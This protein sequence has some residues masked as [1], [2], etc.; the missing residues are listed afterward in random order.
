M[1]SRTQIT[2]DLHGDDHAINSF[3]SPMIINNFME[4]FM[5]Y[6]FIWSGVVLKILD[7]RG[8]QK[9]FWKII[10]VLLQRCPT[11]QIYNW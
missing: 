8:I 4:R 5:S 3:Y 10:K 6:F 11:T 1:H 9:V 7:L 2:V